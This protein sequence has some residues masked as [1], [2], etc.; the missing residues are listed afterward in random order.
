MASESCHHC[1]VPLIKQ[2]RH[3]INEKT[4]KTLDI[5]YGMKP[6]CGRSWLCRKCYRL[7]QTLDKTKRELD[8]R[9]RED[10]SSSSST[11]DSNSD[12]NPTRPKKRKRQADTDDSD[13]KQ[14][15]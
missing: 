4:Q 10:H 13:V 14:V 1:G 11:N 12:S 9:R 5:Y 3:L 6:P 15:S 8:V 7:L 2:L